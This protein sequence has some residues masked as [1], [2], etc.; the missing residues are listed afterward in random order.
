M[1]LL[2][3][4][5]NI[6]YLEKLVIKFVGDSGDGMQLTGSEFAHTSALMGNDI[7]TF[8]NFPAEI[9]APQGSVYGVSGFQVQIGDNEINTAG[10]AVDVLVAMNPAAFKT[11]I[12]D[13]PE[14][15]V[16]I[17][18]TDS[19][20]RKNIQK[21]G[22]EE[23]PLE[24]EYLSKYKVIKAPITSL[25]KENLKDLNIGNKDV[26]RSK[27]MFALGMVFWMYN[28][29][30]SHTIEFLE[31]KF[32]SLPDIAE[33]NILNLKAGFN[34][35]ETLELLPE[36]YIVP[37]AK[38]EKGTYRIITG[39]KA[40]AWGF[41][42][43]SNKANL[44]LFLGSYPITPA[45]DILH[46][47]AKHEA[48]GVKTFQAEDEIAGVGAAIGA[49]F[50]GNLALTTTSGPGM[51]LKAEAIGLALMT[52]LPLVIVNIQRGGPSTGLPTKTEQS[53]LLQAMYGRNGESP[54]IVV[55]A[56]T[57]ANCY[58]WAYEASK[59]SLENMTP[60]V[61]LSDGYI[62]NGSAPW[63]LHKLATMPE[64][65]LPMAKANEENFLPYNRDENLIRKWAIPGTEGLEHRIGGLEKAEYTGAVSYN[66]E[67]HQ[68]MC[69]IRADKIAKIADRIPLAELEGSE[70]ADLL[71]VAWGGTYG[72]T[73]TAVKRINAQ[74]KKVAYL[75]FNYIN[76]MQRNIAEI[77]AR[78][79][80]ILVVELNLGQMV[81]ILRD[82][83]PENKYLQY[84]KVQGMPFA[85]E[86]LINKFDEVLNS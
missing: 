2:N 32:K 40:I 21:A 37:P 53:D 74:G 11:N 55:A 64:I 26:L 48:L 61:L 28:R 45:S 76:P 79:P 70:D 59:L 78:Y 16:L 10:D 44:P 33:A 6:Q 38:L 80:K 19:F 25:T 3:E 62:A 47:L 39:N 77:L 58:N 54:V 86:E 12:A 20:S 83:F 30:L 43:A 65:T 67:N 41:I 82:R 8:P 52:E 75:H 14:G 29:P 7:S 27:N 69:E 63:K 85:V 73:H 66:A 22:C 51:A 35:A 18:D 9:R 24:A 68:R 5:K 72:S 81:K 31:T 36:S 23:N 71:V 15:K 84:N 57:S 13:L 42:A 1:T 17:V 50:A 49:A 60:V 4:N 34:Y 56:S 46:E